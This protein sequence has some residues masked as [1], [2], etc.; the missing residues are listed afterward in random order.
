[1][2]GPLPILKRASRQL[3]LPGGPFPCVTRGVVCEE[4]APDLRSGVVDALGNRMVDAAIPSMMS[5]GRRKP[6]R[7]PKKPV[8]YMSDMAYNQHDG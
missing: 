4:L 1:M 7:I 6:F 3:A 8:D 5:T 2:I